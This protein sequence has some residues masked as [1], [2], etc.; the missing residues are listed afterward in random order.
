VVVVVV[1]VVVLMH[2][3]DSGFYDVH[4]VDILRLH[5]KDVCN[6]KIT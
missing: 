4:G 2:K 5:Y 3:D 1:V 6:F